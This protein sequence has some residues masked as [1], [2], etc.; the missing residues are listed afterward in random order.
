MKLIR[1]YR[2]FSGGRPAI[3]VS[4]SSWDFGATSVGT[5][6][7][8]EFTIQNTGTATLTI[9]DRSYPSG[10]SESVALS[11]A[12]LAPGAS[13]TF[14]V[15]ATAV[16][17]QIF[18]GNISI[19][20]NAASS[21]T[22]VA[23][24]VNVTHLFEDEFI[25]AD[26]APLTSPRTAEPGPGSWTV[27]NGANLSISNGKLVRSGTATLAS[28]ATY[29]RTNLAF[30]MRH[31]A[32]AADGA[33]I[34]FSAN[35]I[36]LQSGLTIGIASAAPT[37]VGTGIF[38]F[39]DGLFPNSWVDVLVIERPS[40]GV[41]MY[42]RGANYGRW[43]LVWVSIAE[44]STPLYAFYKGAVGDVGL[45][46]DAF[47]T[48]AP[49]EFLSQFGNALHY[50]ASPVA[51]LTSAAAK[52]FQEISWTPAS[53]EILEMT[54]NE[55]DSNNKIILRCNQAGSTIALISKVAGVET[56]LQSAA[57]TWTIGSPYRV[58]MVNHHYLGGTRLNAVVNNNTLLAVASPITP[59]MAYATGCR[60]SGFT[61]ATDWAVWQVE[62]IELPAPFSDTGFSQF[63]TYGDSKTDAYKV[64][65][66]LT[67]LLEDD[68]G[69]RWIYDSVARSGYTVA[70]Q[71]AQIAT[72]LANVASSVN[73]S[74]VIINLGS[75][76]AGSL[77]SE[78][79]WKANYRIIIE[80]IHAKW[81]NATIYL[82][83]PVRLSGAPPSTP[84]AAVATMH[85]YIDGLIAEYAYVEEG[86]D[87]IDLENGDGY[88]TYL[89][90]I[91]H[92][93]NAGYAQ[94]AVLQMTAM[95]L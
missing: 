63:W 3:S 73:P 94:C 43:Q 78:A 61:T 92:P 42:L 6:V 18:S 95:G 35:G 46:D 76:D 91:T 45:S 23:V 49:S 60:I 84:V 39:I 9:G 74:F 52:V 5:P 66:R 26:A 41:W 28:V 71:A 10:Y 81:S 89:A 38:V 57:Q 75:N 17:G 87:E 20:S 51:G 70:L 19:A 82:A 54:L 24:T 85:G 50:E 7:T 2:Y 72:D 55:V 31:L 44:T 12:S 48:L 83:K 64:Q 67:T 90:D 80:A 34:G 53:A 14:T 37:T 27:T 40:G 21:P 59:T 68:S 33:L 30:Y 69:N 13:A 62:P 11:S 15:Q 65:A 22:L 88:V 58:I 16:T 56:S 4:P 86:F 77:P 93:N 47:L 32:T 25:T 8:K 29:A 36:H 1:R 79:T